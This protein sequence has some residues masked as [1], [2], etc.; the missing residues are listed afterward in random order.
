MYL[1]EA[2]RTLPRA[3]CKVCI[4]TNQEHMRAFHL[5]NRLGFETLFDDMFYS[6]RLGALKPQRAF[7]EAVAH[8]IGPQSEA[9]LLFDDSEA[10]IEAARAF[11]WEAVLYQ[12]LSDFSDH[13]WVRAARQLGAA[14]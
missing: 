3:A 2:I 7:F 1:I 8:R 4:A 14:G 6:A 11:G 12:N 9:P 10:V 13:A 5:W